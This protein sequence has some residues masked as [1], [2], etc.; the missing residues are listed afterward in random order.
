MRFLFWLLALW[1][2]TGFA[3]QLTP[4][5]F[6]RITE[7]RTLFYSNNGEVYGVE[8]YLPDRRVIW[9]FDNGQC[10]DGIWYPRDG[11]ICFIYE[12]ID[13]T[14]QCWVFEQGPSGLIAYFNGSTQST[15]LIETPDAGREMTC[16]GPKVGV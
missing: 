3:G 8:R 12:G 9:S 2:I 15:Q 11:Q 13:P 7:G 14:P 16:L 10:Q 5:E 6:E 4:E 1:P